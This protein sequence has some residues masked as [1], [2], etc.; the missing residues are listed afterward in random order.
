MAKPR[1]EK[2]E[3]DDARA[4]VCEAARLVLRS[5]PT[6]AQRTEPEQLAINVL[7]DTVAKLDDAERAMGIST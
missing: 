2:Q 7:R 4:L 6:V 3:L 1:T 5:Q